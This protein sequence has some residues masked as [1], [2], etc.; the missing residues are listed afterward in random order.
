MSSYSAGYGTAQGGGHGSVFALPAGL[1][2]GGVV[3][4][5]LLAS[6]KG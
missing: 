3:R 5:G 1:T 6:Q 4:R 2:N